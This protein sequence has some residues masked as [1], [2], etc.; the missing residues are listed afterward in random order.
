MTTASALYEVYKTLPK[1][2]RK[3][4]KELIK[5]EEERPSALMSEIEEG[6]KQVKEIRAG[7]VKPKSIKEVLHG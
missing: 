2:T 4:F 5:T 6:L 3:A 1:Q 7:K